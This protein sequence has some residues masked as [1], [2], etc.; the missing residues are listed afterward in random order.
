MPL[1]QTS[2]K[3][4]V[5]DECRQLNLTA[6]LE[7][8]YVKDRGMKEYYIPIKKPEKR[9]EPIGCTFCSILSR[10]AFMDLP[11]KVTVTLDE[12]KFEL[13]AIQMKWLD[14]YRRCDILEKKALT[15]IIC[16]QRLAQVM[17]NESFSKIDMHNRLEANGYAMLEDTSEQKENGLRPPSNRF[18]AQ[19]IL[20]W[21]SKCE[22][23]DQETC[24]PVKQPI[25]DLYLIDC[26][27]LTVV[28]APIQSRYVALSY[29]WARAGSED[30]AYRLRY[31]EDNQTF[32]L[33][34]KLPLVVT[35]AIIVT[36]S[37][38]F[39]YLWV[40]KFC[41]AQHQPEVK[42][43]Q[44]AQMDA[45]YTN[46]VLTIIA[47]AGQDENYGLPGVSSRPRAVTPTAKIGD[48]RVI[49]FQHPHSSIRKSKWYTRA[50]T[51][52]EA[53]LPTR[54]LVF[55]DHQTYM[56]CEADEHCDMTLRSPSMHLFQLRKGGKAGLWNLRKEGRGKG[57]LMYYKV[58][59]SEYVPREVGYDSDSLLAL[60]GILAYLQ[61]TQPGFRH[62][63]GVPWRP[64]PVQPG[65]FNIFA[66]GL[67]WSHGRRCWDSSR[68]PRRRSVPPS[69]T[70]PSSTPPSWTWAG[71]AGR[72]GTLAIVRE[73]RL[74]MRPRQFWLEDQHGHRSAVGAV[75]DSNLS[76]MFRYRI[77][78]IETWAMSPDKIH[79]Q[80]LPN[81]S[82]DW[83]VH[84]HK[85]IGVALSEGAESEAELAKKLERKGGR[86]RCIFLGIYESKS[87]PVEI[88]VHLL[89]LR[90]EVDEDLWVRVG[91]MT[92]R[93]EAPD[94]VE[95]FGES[96]PIEEFRIK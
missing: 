57:L 93:C 80:E 85:A 8:E 29:V 88:D 5:C 90:Q 24:C 76:Q 62:I 64:L 47:A 11:G 87:K 21:I 34:E 35:D 16:S 39:R 4:S 52:Q 50:W 53:F 59:L 12:E 30:T 28:A 2:S 83:N 95:L 20:D 3:Q 65:D 60:A 26:H 38:G 67:C 73:S 58:I 49:W 10:S 82:T 89:I 43:K 70:T 46:S 17:Q 69:S 68:K 72:I 42:H 79:F 66:A 14:S 81:D 61:R 92:L 94:M 19:P 23:H 37:L 56:E 36:K 27:E 86:W 44:I 78:V 31:D 55:L 74:S 91:R 71:W 9:H 77:L 13:R 22:R 45:V 7:S 6:F 15:L 41:I 40:D 51:Y 96:L 25:C 63:W 48:S 18:S 1:T 33:P 84:G 32:F 75:A 54:R